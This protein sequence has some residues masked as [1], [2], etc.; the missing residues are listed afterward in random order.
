MC[1]HDVITPL[2][3]VLTCLGLLYTLFLFSESDH[4][5]KKQEKD[6]SKRKD[7]KKKAA[8][9]T[10]AGLQEEEPQTA[11]LMSF[12][13]PSHIAASVLTGC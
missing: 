5:L 12:T 6:Q 8:I 7:V 11:H 10:C 3:L 1:L 4:Y 9:I 2:Y 13:W